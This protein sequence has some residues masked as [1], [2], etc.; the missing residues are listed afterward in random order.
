MS[1]TDTYTDRQFAHE[2]VGNDI[3]GIPLANIGA[4]LD[5][6]GLNWAV[7]AID[8][9]YE[10]AGEVRTA[11]KRALVRTDTGDQL[12]THSGTY[13]RLENSSLVDLAAAASGDGGHGIEFRTGGE[14]DG[15]RVVWLNA[16]LGSNPRFDGLGISKEVTVVKSHDGTLP[17]MFIPA[18]VRMFCRNQF[19][20]LRKTH[21]RIVVRHTAN[22]QARLAEAKAAVTAMYAAHDAMDEMLADLLE[23]EI[24]NRRFEAIAR[25]VIG[26]WSDVE[27]TQKART[28]HENM[29]NVIEATWRA[30][31][32]LHGTGLGVVN[33]FNDFDLW[34]ST[35]RSDRTRPE[36]QLNQLVRG[37]MPRTYAAAELVLA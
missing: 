17:L 34:D 4:V 37:S 33:A 9:T 26:D 18:A 36:A 31:D 16:S 1:I 19:P 20:M 2:A 12:G 10:F 14:M 13:M 8:T 7:E 27:A 29:W 21:G 6:A 15:G 25:E 11:D 3:A 30:N 22:A 23:T 28:Q 24:T 35:I 5:A 32:D